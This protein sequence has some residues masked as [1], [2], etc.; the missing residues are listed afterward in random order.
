MNFS[1]GAV[2]TPTGEEKVENS[3][4]L[5]G[6]ILYY[7]QNINEFK[8]F[9]DTIQSY[10]KLSEEKKQKLEKEASSMNEEDLKIKIPKYIETF[11]CQCYQDWNTVTK[12]CS[13]CGK[14][15]W[16]SITINKCRKWF[17]DNERPTFNNLMNLR[18]QSPALRREL[19]FQSKLEFY[20]FYLIRSELS[21]F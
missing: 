6:E 15:D 4:K 1:F 16:D 14:I 9:E 18:N 2:S 13:V 10:K 19:N 11:S 8:N 3:V 5:N 20:L 12:P 21:K 7:Y 17:S